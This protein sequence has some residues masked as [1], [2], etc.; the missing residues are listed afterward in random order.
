MAIDTQ[1]ARALAE[2][3]AAFHA[4]LTAAEA[5]ALEEA[6]LDAAGED[7]A[8]YSAGPNVT[9]ARMLRRLQSA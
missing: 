4:S 6:L 7:T 9:V 2:K 1:A 3:L 8:G 5:E